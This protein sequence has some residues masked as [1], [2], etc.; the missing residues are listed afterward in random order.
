VIQRKKEEEETGT[1]D[2]ERSLQYFESKS[3]KKHIQVQIKGWNLRRQQKW[4]RFRLEIQHCF[5]GL[6]GKCQDIDG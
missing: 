2:S 5:R 6:M 1:L 3:N 4:K